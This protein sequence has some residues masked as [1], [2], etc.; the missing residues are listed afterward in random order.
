MKKSIFIN[1]VI[2]N[3]LLLFISSTV[4]GI[5]CIGE[6]KNYTIPVS[7]S[8]DCTWQEENY[9]GHRIDVSEDTNR[10]KAMK[11]MGV[12]VENDNNGGNS[13][14]V[15]NKGQMLAVTGPTESW[16]EKGFGFKLAHLLSIGD[17]YVRTV[18]PE[19][20]NV[21]W[22]N[23]DKWKGFYY[24]EKRGWNELSYD[25]Q[26]IP[27]FSDR[28]LPEPPDIKDLPQSFKQ[29]FD[30]WREEAKKIRQKTDVEPEY[31][32]YSAD[33]TKRRMEVIWDVAREDNIDPFVYLSIL[34]EEGTGSFNTH[35]I[36]KR[37]GDL[38]YGQPHPNGTI[39]EWKA[40]VEM[41]S[42]IIKRGIRKYN[43]SGDPKNK[44][45]LYWVGMGS[46]DIKANGAPEFDRGYCTLVRWPS[47]VAR[48]Y[49]TIFDNPEK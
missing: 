12:V 36:E 3:F 28:G 4:Y 9:T 19:N 17:H 32:D 47:D 22:Y 26:D 39:Q 1:V 21:Q 40:D 48:I 2:F 29:Y 20:N 7:G 10:Q 14:Y 44:G 8:I 30:D 11:L 24:T 6:D 5:S 45:W 41:A 42:K 31:A 16:N 43:Q 46:D 34:V 33:L 13:V 37:N 38:K 27:E 49:N 35:I 15:K 25:P 23:V 18:N